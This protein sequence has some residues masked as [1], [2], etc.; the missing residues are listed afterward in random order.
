MSNKYCPLCREENKCTKDANC[1]CNNE[2]FPN[3]IFETV[4]AKSI[5]KDCICQ[6]CL[7]N[8]KEKVDK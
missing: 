2:E 3:E 1:W 8:F 7:R 6:K 5:R 4:P